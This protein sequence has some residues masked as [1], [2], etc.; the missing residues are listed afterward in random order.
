MKYDHLWQV[1]IAIMGVTKTKVT[2]ELKN[3]NITVGK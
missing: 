2:R 3:W 1:C